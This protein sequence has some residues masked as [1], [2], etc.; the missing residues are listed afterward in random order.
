[1]SE[2]DEWRYSVEEVEYINTDP[3]SSFRQKAELLTGVVFTLLLLWI[4]FAVIQSGMSGGYEYFGLY[5]L[6]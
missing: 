4:I 3:P 5:I 1:M 2:E 6:S